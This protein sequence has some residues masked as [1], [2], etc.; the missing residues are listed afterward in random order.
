MTENADLKFN[1]A[2]D[3]E[4]LDRAEEELYQILIERR[5]AFITRWYSG[6]FFTR[7]RPLLRTVGLVLSVMGIGL[8]LVALLL[9]PNWC[10]A[11][12]QAELFLVLFVFL[13]LLFYFMP[14]FEMR[15]KA[16]SETNALKNCRKM[17][18]RCVRDARKQAPFEAEYKV[19]NNK[20]VYS[21]VKGEDL[22]QVWSR[23]LKG[24]AAHGETATLIFRKEKSILPAMVILHESFSQLETLLRQQD[25]QYS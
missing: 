8:C 16:W 13:G 21:R 15:M 4:F 12:F 22:Q 19:E 1:S 20:I 7:I 6:V 9:S 23:P 14:V 17:A 25:I 2:I 18:V 24:I 5:M 3:A 10:P 11:F